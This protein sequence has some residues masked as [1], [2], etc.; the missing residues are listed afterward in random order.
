MNFTIDTHWPLSW[1]TS[2][3]TCVQKKRMGVPQVKR[4][5]FKLLLLLFIY[6]LVIFS[7]NIFCFN[8]FTGSSNIWLYGGQIFQ[9]TIDITWNGSVGLLFICL[10]VHAKLLVLSVCESH[11]ECGRVCLHSDCSYSH[12]WSLYGWEAI[13]CLWT[14]LYSH[15]IWYRFGLLCWRISIRL[16]MGSQNNSHHFLQFFDTSVS[17]PLWSS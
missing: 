1:S 9:K 5:F 10:N 2:Q 4:D 11:A 15:T 14:V 8:S 16:E 13:T 6:W 7:R 12:W 17:V 3:K